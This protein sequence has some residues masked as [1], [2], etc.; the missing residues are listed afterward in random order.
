MRILCFGSLNIDY[1]YTVEHF[2]SK[3]ETISSA[4]MERNI[5]G[6]GLNQSVALARAGAE[7]YHAGQVG[8]DGVFLTE[9]L[10][11]NGVDTTYIKTINSPSGHAIIQVDSTGDNCIIIHGGANTCISTDY[12]DSVLSN[13]T[14]GDV[15]LMQNEINNGAYLLRKAKECGLITVLNPSPITGLDLPLELVDIF[16]LNETEAEGLFATD[17]MDIIDSMRS[18]YPNAKFVMTLGEKGSVYIDADDVVKVDA[19]ATDVVDTTAAGDTFTGYFL[20][21]LFAGD[22]PKV[23]ME[24]AARASSITISKKGAAKTIPHHSKVLI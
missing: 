6:K 2:V 20:T 21:R 22:I 23:A 1:V 8:S 4:N 17:G 18:H 19:V 10:K 11:E 16:V 5:G 13:F 24:I 7:V 9:F 14:G 3:G 15:L 12:I